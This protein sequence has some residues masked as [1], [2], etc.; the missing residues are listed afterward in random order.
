MEPSAGIF[1]R[2]SVYLDRYVQIG[3][4]GNRLI[5]VSFPTEDP[6]D[7]GDEHP[8]LDEIQRYLDG[9]RTDFD[10]VELAMTVDTDVMSV[11]DVVRTIPYGQMRDL[12][13]IARMTPGLTADDEGDLDTVRHALE[14]NPIPLI[15]PDH[16]VRDGA[17]AAPA[18]VVRRLREL[19]G[20][21]RG[22]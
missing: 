11:L 6:P 12:A 10:D 14:A 22:V 3:V 1:T 20:L 16:R 19:E 7:A 4:A 13:A 17:Q 2:E 8:I 5:S 18:S 21:S 9:V 15:I